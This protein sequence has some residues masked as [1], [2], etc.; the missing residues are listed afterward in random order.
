MEYSNG[1][2]VRIGDRV[3]IDN[4]DGRGVI[5]SGHVIGVFPPGSPEARDYGCFETGG[6]LISLDN[7]DCQLWVHPDEHLVLLNEQ[8]DNS[9]I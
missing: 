7:G 6:V 3:G 1:K 9:A 5:T 4:L 8:G 2:K